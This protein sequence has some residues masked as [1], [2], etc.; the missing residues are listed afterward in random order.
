MAAHAF[1]CLDTHATTIYPN[2]SLM[3]VL[4]QYAALPSH[5]ADDAITWRQVQTYVD[6]QQAIADNQT[7]Y[8]AAQESACP[9]GY[10]QVVVGEGSPPIRSRYQVIHMAA[11]LCVATGRWTWVVV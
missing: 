11:A 3:P 6:G 8:M 9:D 5:E 1:C 10:H 4:R 2:L 7:C